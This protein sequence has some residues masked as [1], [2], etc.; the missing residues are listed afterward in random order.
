MAGRRSN[1]LIGMDRHGPHGGPRDDKGF[2]DPPYHGGPVYFLATDSLVF[3]QR[4]Q[5]RR[6]ALRPRSIAP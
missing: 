5:P 4:R 3:F 6:V 1:P 2:E